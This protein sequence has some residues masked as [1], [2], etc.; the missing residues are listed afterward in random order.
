MPLFV[1]RRVVLRTQV[2]LMGWFVL[3]MVWLTAAFIVAMLG[4]YLLGW[5]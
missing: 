5:W 2:R 1:H 4:R 3:A